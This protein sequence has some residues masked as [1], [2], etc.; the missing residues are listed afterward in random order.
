MNYRILEGSHVENGIN[1]EKGEVCE[2]P[3]DLVALFGDNKFVRTN[4]PVT[5]KDKRKPYASP[6]VSSTVIE[7][8]DED[9]GDAENKPRRLGEIESS[10]GTN[11]TE[12]F[13]SAFDNGLLVY[14]N[15]RNYFIAD[16]DDPET[17]LNGDKITS[18]R[19]VDSFLEE[20]L[21]SR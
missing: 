14:Q 6:P 2:S 17:A 5:R 13:D 12:S 18:R 15:G 1:Y 11:V 19:G 10:L 21:E 20:F 9:P 8:E 7:E 16:P 3:Y 4:K